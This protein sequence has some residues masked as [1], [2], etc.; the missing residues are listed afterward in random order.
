MAVIA[1]FVLLGASFA[2]LLIGRWIA[3]LPVAAIV[4]PAATFGGP[5]GGALAALAAAGFLAGVQLH[6]VV[7]EQYPT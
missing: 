5:E 4:G 3:V 2:G 6:Q 7:A 1:L